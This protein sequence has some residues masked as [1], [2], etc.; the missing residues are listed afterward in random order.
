M[1][2]NKSN[3]N[4]LFELIPAPWLLSHLKSWGENP[5]HGEKVCTVHVHSKIQC[6]VSPFG[7]ISSWWDGNTYPV[8]QKTAIS[9][10]WTR[11]CAMVYNNGSS[12]FT[13]VHKVFSP[14]V[15]VAYRKHLPTLW[16][17]ETANTGE[18]HHTPNLWS[19]LVAAETPP[20]PPLGSDSTQQYKKGTS[21]F[22]I[23][24]VLMPYKTLEGLVWCFT[25]RCF[26]VSTLGRPYHILCHFLYDNQLHAFTFLLSHF[27]VHPIH[28]LIPFIS[29]T[30]KQELQWSIFTNLP[31]LPIPNPQGNSACSHCP[32]YTTGICAAP[33]NV[34]QR[35]FSSL[36]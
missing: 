3:K 11:W 17:S 32:F 22:S 35:T 9:Q 10:S 8:A 34:E 23:K 33:L 29:H 6:V 2:I 19:P 26:G 36:T 7:R 30:R 16:S 4:L 28:Q 1:Q 12:K 5:L 18:H 27:G 13:F 20:Q 15:G 24:H 31:S 14:Y 21:S 25:M